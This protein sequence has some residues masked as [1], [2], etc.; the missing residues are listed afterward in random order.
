MTRSEIEAWS[1]KLTK[2]QLLDILWEAYKKVSPAKRADIDAMVT[3]TVMGFE[4]ISN[5]KGKVK[6]TGTD[7]DAREGAFR[8]AEEQA[9]SFLKYAWLRYYTQTAGFAGVISRENYLHWDRQ[10]KAFL[11]TVQGIGPDSPS[12]QKAVDLLI[13]LY[14]L[15]SFSCIYK[16]LRKER[17]FQTIGIQQEAFLRQLVDKIWLAYPREEAIPRLVKAA[18]FLGRDPYETDMIFLGQIVIRSLKTD[19]DRQLALAEAKRLYETNEKE[20]KSYYDPA[21]D[22]EK[23]EYYMA[24][25]QR[26]L[27]DLLG[28]L[29]CAVSREEMERRVREDLAGRVDHP[30]YHL[31]QFLNHTKD[32]G[33]WKQIYEIGVFLG[34]KPTEQDQ[35]KYQSLTAAT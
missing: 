15:F 10:V 7:A 9:R 2:Q 35:K 26:D 34:I 17:P 33:I 24:V 3:D 14:E 16:L 1:K 19:E 6:E 32:N 8:A 30:E 29:E 5:M 12:F 23:N 13:D 22:R 20:P 31:Y 18:S 11:P 4:S 28:M 25:H 27:R 21:Q